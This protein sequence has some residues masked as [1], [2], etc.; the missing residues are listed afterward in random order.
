MLTT[1]K[2][3]LMLRVSPFISKKLQLPK[4]KMISIKSK[5]ISIP[6]TSVELPRV[7]EEDV[8]FIQYTSGST[9]TPK[10]VTVCNK[11]VLH[12]LRV[13]QEEFGEI[14]PEDLGVSWA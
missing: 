7:T 13:L 14:T 8:A 4:I 11:N 2:L 12:N 1:T 9:S 5:P 3:K 10:G 6:E